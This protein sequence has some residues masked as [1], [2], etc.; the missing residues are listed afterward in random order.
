MFVPPTTQINSTMHHTQKQRKYN[1]PNRFFS[2]PR[3]NKTA[4][5]QMKPLLDEINIFP[6]V[7]NQI[8]TEYTDNEQESKR[9]DACCTIL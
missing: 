5:W 2:Y 3:N 9:T 4:K 7:L 1:N 8:I 6:S